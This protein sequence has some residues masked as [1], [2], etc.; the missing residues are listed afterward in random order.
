MEYTAKKFKMI[1]VVSVGLVVLQRL[2]MMQIA[3]R[4]AVRM[5]EG[6]TSA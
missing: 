2:A 4:I 6:T 5:L 1:L 3:C